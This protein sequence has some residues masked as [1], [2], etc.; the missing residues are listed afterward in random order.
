VLDE[1]KLKIFHH[2]L[3]WSHFEDCALICLFYSYDYEQ[4][5]EALSGVSGQEYSIHD[6][7]D[8]GAR[9]QTL[10]RLFNLREGFTAADDRLPK[11]VMTAFDSGP[12]AGSAI[13]AEDLERFKRR[14]YE[15]MNWEPETGVPTEECLRELGLDRL[16]E[17]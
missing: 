5:A 17:L 13:A 8:V 12:I 11:R 14:F 15:V 2:E 10:A 16:L 3:N 4:L 1:D 7:L 9:A 6:I